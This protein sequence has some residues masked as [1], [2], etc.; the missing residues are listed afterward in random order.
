MTP[1]RRTEDLIVELASGAGAVTPLPPVWI[2]VARWWAVTVAGTMLVVAL[3]GIRPDL[4]AAAGSAAFMTS[5]LFGLAVALVAGAAAL[6][7]SVPG[8]TTRPWLERMPVIASMVWAAWLLSSARMSDQSLLNEPW[9]LACA[10]RASLLAALPGAALAVGVR[11]GL[12]LDPS[13]AA[14]MTAVAGAALAAGTVQ[15]TCP[16]DRAAHV[17]VAHLAP[18]AVLATAC[19]VLLRPLLS[20]R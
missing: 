1:D 12:V 7:L 10:G 2:R 3:I 17:L 5:A 6:T 16:I 11:R 20:D 13:R 18:M 4:G 15:L 9:H 14:F 19:G 8:A